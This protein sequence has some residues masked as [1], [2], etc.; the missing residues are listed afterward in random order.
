MDAGDR[1]RCECDTR[2]APS[3]TPN[4]ASTSSAVEGAQQ[5][6]ETGAE[7]SAG[8]Q[9]G[10][11]FLRWRKVASRECHARCRRRGAARAGQVS[12][13]VERRR[14]LRQGRA[15]HSQFEAVTTVITLIGRIGPVPRVGAKSEEPSSRATRRPQTA[16]KIVAAAEQVSASLA[17]SRLPAAESDHRGARRHASTAQE[18]VARR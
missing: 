2:W 9:V 10:E 5:I 18:R 7:R 6:A 14:G 12:L 15:V 1:A 13:G 4:S 16:S 8:E 11:G 17:T 3:S